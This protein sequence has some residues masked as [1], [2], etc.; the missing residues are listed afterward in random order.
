[1]TESLLEGDRKYTCCRC[2]EILDLSK[3]FYKCFSDLYSDTGY[4]PVCKSCFTKIID[5]YTMKYGSQREAMKRACMAFD[6]YYNDELF[7]QVEDDDAFIGKYLRGLNRTQYRKKTFD[8]S[9]DEGATI[10]GVMYDKKA[11]NL[12]DKILAAEEAEKDKES[13]IDPADIKKWGAGFAKEDYAEMNR[14]YALLKAANPRAD[15]NQ[16][17]YIMDCC[18]IKMHQLKASR[19][20][21]LDDFQKMTDLYTKTYKSGNLKSIG[22]TVADEFVYGVTVDTI[23]QTTPAEYYKNKSLHKDFDGIGDYFQRMIVRPVRNIILGTK[24]K[25]Y[26]FYVKDEDEQVIDSGDADE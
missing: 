19:E 14:H 2:R 12:R 24:E 26:E 17:N 3:D 22:D 9:L 18:Q 15:G 4:M 23:E 13:S 25:D 7:D 10:A 8:N 20:G 11:R 16:E 6:I 1:M 21:R 5:T